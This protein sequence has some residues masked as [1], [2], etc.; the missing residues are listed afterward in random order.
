MNTITKKKPKSNIKSK[1]WYA[2]A[3]SMS[4]GWGNYLKSIDQLKDAVQ[5]NE[6]ISLDDYCWILY[7]EGNCSHTW[8]AFKKYC[9]QIL[10]ENRRM[11]YV[12]WTGLFK[13]WCDTE[14]DHHAL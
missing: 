13:K 6:E 9:I 10:P 11:L 14:Y 4:D 5:Y 7:G 1:K 3:N 2:K 12:C 8:E